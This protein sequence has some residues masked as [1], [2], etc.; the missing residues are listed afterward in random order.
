[1]VQG[2][3]FRAHGGESRVGAE[4]HDPCAREGRGGI[5]TRGQSNCRIVLASGGALGLAGESGWA[6]KSIA[7][8]EHVGTL[9]P[10]CRR[11]HSRR[12]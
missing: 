3:R 9:N 1:L 8:T 12:A 11:A 10:M 7:Y 4:K 2:F 6:S 5:V